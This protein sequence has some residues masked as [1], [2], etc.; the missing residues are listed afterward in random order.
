MP[1]SCRA[2]WHQY[3]IDSTMR[4]RCGVKLDSGGR[5]MAE[6]AR[7]CRLALGCRHKSAGQL[8]LRLTE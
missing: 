5:P 3:R 4:R 6:A 1:I 2:V 7:N 8:R